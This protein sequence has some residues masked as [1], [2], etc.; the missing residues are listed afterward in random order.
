LGKP[1]LY[2]KMPEEKMLEE[3]KKIEITSIIV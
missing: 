1:R 3:M 2:K